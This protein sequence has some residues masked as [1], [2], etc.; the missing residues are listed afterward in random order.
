VDV[1]VGSDMVVYC[2]EGIGQSDERGRE[3]RMNLDIPKVG[4]RVVAHCF[5]SSL[6][7]EK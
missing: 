1:E 2:C 7:S 5:A 3:K 6:M 4:S